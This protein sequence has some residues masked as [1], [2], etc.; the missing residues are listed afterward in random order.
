MKKLYIIRHAK[1]SWHFNISK[2]HDRPLNSRGRLQVLK[3]GKYLAKN[4]KPPDQIIT[5]TAS[6]A[7]YTALFIADAWKIEENKILLN[8]SFYNADI[9]I[10][11]DIIR[12]TDHSDILAICG[13]NPVLTALINKFH[14]KS[15]NNLPTCGIMGFSFNIENWRSLNSADLLPDFYYTPRSIYGS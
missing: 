14:A 13:H 3:M 4:V 15:I 5:S 6:R 8:D 12:N 9:K 1:S 2:D 7:F 11:L 10:L